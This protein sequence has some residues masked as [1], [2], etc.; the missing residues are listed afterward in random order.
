[1]WLANN[2]SDKKWELKAYQF[3]ELIK[4]QYVES[5]RVAT[6]QGI[7]ETV[8]KTFQDSSNAAAHWMVGVEGSR[9]SS[10]KDNGQAIGRGAD[11]RG[12]SNSPPKHPMVG[13]RG[14]EGSNS[15]AVFKY[16]PG[17]EFESVIGKFIRG[18]KP[19]IDV[20]FFN[21]LADEKFGD[22]AARANLQ[23]AAELGLQR[24]IDV[25]KSQTRTRQVSL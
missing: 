13:Y 10:R 24:M 7:R 1:M 9:P 23:E 19:R 5:I 4:Q 3:G 16:V 6:N 20:Y 11:M 2:M 12:T 21:A 25:F 15:H 14:D 22:Y 17:R 18:A 8:N